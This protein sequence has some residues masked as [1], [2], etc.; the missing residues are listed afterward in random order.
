MLACSEDG[1][2]PPP[3]GAGISTSTAVPCFFAGLLTSHVRWASTSPVFFCHVHTF[4]IGSGLVR[5]WFKLGLPV[6]YLTTSSVVPAA[7]PLLRSRPR[8]PLGA[9]LPRY[10]G[11]GI[12]ACGHPTGYRHI[13]HL[14]P[15][16]SRSR[17]PCTAKIYRAIRVRI[18]RAALRGAPQQHA[19]T[20]QQT[21]AL[22]RR[23]RT[24]GR[25]HTESA[26]RNSGY[27][28]D[29]AAPAP[30]P[31]LAFGA[32]MV[33][34]MRGLPQALRYCTSGRGALPVQRQRHPTS[35]EVLHKG[36]GDAARSAAETCSAPY[37]R[38]ASTTSCHRSRWAQTIGTTRDQAL[39]RF[40]EL[41]FGL[42]LGLA[43]DGGPGFCGLPARAPPLLL[44]LCGEP[45]FPL[46]LLDPG[47]RSGVSSSGATL[48]PQHGAHMHAKSLPIKA[49]RPNRAGN[50]VRSMFTHSSIVTS[51]KCGNRP[52][53]ASLPTW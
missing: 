13:R 48:E 45:F 51:A 32:T 9:P 44:G 46:L 2:R 29:V 28:G 18:V 26:P 43:D 20:S 31:S 3:A 36:P 33:V 47:G 25:S 7:A 38:A 23:S 50:T 12:S 19:C 53:A 27:G 24:R 17:N 22:K 42:A 6:P 40:L 16:T 49:T 35:T 30:T 14:L 1:A 41:P 39:S 37:V 11:V 4:N 10:F 34:H 15:P 8:A 52:R 21:G 5:L